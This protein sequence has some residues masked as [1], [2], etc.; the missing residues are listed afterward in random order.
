MTWKHFLSRVAPVPLV[1]LAI[2]LIVHPAASQT[3]PA[4]QLEQ[5]KAAEAF[6]ATLAP[7]GSADYNRIK[8]SVISLVASAPVPSA[9]DLHESTTPSVSDDPR[10]QANLKLMIQQT[11]SGIHDRIFGGALS[12]AKEFPATVAVYGNGGLCSGTLIAPNAVLTAQHCPCAG[13]DEHVAFGL[14]WQKPSAVYDVVKNETMAACGASNAGQDVALLFLDKVA[15]VAPAKLLASAST[16]PL[17]DVRAVGYGLT[18]TNGSGLQ[19]NVDLPVASPRCNGSSHGETDSAYFGCA[20]GS[21][22][23]A[24]MQNSKRDTCHGDS[25]GPL[26]M[27]SAT[28]GY[29][30]VA[31]TSRG[32]STPGAAD[33][34]DGGIYE[35][36][37]G[38]ILTWI[39]S[40]G[41]QPTFSS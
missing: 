16:V 40:K 32:V 18:E 17:V 19:L 12:L 25:G 41:V 10:F 34:G 8:K 14:D 3:A 7:P 27:K 20:T 2:A 21:E 29:L 26:F 1:L 35:V 33:C 15:A 6:A 30:L 38:K 39:R 4:N 23:V 31:S 13:V 22:M 24:G 37:D 11:A 36:L 28:H 9:R 5:A